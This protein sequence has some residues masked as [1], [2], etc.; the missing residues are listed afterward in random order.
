A[1]LAPGGL[2]LVGSFDGQLYAI[3]PDGT[4]SF[5]F[6][7]GDR[8]VSSVLVD[9]K[10]AVLFGSQDDRVYA[11]EPDGRLRWSVELDGD[12]D[13]SPVLG[14]DGTIYVGSDDKKLYALRA[15]QGQAAGAP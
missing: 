8:I 14:S 10:G 15:P 5:T 3:K 12:V 9:V 2:I 11:L 6:R 4:L 7:T 1:A 13:S